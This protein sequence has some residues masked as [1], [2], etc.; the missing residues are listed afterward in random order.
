MKSI[1]LVLFLVLCAYALDDF[2]NTGVRLALKIYDD[3]SKTDGFSPCLKKKAI[4]FLDRL[5]RM[6]N[7]SL[8]DGVV[9]QKTADAPKD[10]PAITEEQLDQTLPRSS[11]G[12]DAAL[13]EMLMDKIS[14]FFG[15]RSIEVALPRID[16]SV[17]TE[18]GR[19]G[20]FG[21]GGG[22]H[23]HHGGGGGGGGGGHGGGL[24]GLGGHHGGGGGG[25]GKGKKKGGGGGMNGI[26]MLVGAKMATLGSVAI[27]ALFLLVKKAFIVAKLAL[28]I[29][30]IIGIKEL[31]AKKQGGGASVITVGGGGGDHHHGGGGTEYHVAGGGGGGGW[32]SSGGGWDKRTQAFVIM[33]VLF[34]MVLCVDGFSWFSFGNGV[35]EFIWNKTAPTKGPIEETRKKKKGKKFMINLVLA[36][37]IIKSVLMPIAIKVMAVMSSVSVVLSTMS[38]IISSLIGYSKLAWRHAGPTIKFIQGKD[39]WSKDENIV[40]GLSDGLDYLG[41]SSGLG[42]DIGTGTLEHLHYYQ[43]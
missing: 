29:S 40:T 41:P 13:T 36:L 15:S 1:V 17:L 30:G 8:A 19:F 39:P 20:D 32:Q 28:L 26:M 35:E 33:L 27:A 9:V 11:E 31:L 2:E 10:E 16:A 42:H 25:K 18:A 3:C 22:G 34:A 7:L 21:D 37:F 14:K 24:G 12:K 43:K 23:G 6:D 5:G 4:T 38:L